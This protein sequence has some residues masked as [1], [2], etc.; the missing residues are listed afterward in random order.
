MTAQQKNGGF[1]LMEMVLAIGIFSLLLIALL[2]LLDT[3]TSLWKS[4]DA[5]RERTEA[6]G[7]LGE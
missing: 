7:G 2:Q 5:R 6:S 4:V 3:S 1:T